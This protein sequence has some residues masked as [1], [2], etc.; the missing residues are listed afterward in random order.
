MSIE[1]QTELSKA[2][3][4]LAASL[5]SALD[6]LKRYFSVCRPESLSYETI[7]A[8]SLKL[9]GAATELDLNLRAVTRLEYPNPTRVGCCS[10]VPNSLTDKWSCGRQLLNHLLECSP[11]YEEHAAMRRNKPLQPV[12]QD[13][14]WTMLLPDKEGTP[15][16]ISFENRR[17]GGLS[18]TPPDVRDGGA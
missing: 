15:E 12:A 11:C 9:A 6:R 8:A 18:A 2:R 10:Y 16:T 3:E 17:F 13:L 1:E 5:F 4:A 7:A 14:L